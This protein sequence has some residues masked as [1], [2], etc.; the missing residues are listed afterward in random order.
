MYVGSLEKL[1]ESQNLIQDQW[2]IHPWMH[3]VYRQSHH[4]TTKLVAYQSQWSF[5]PVSSPGWT[6]VLTEFVISHPNTAVAQRQVLKLLAVWVVWSVFSSNLLTTWID[7]PVSLRQW[8]SNR[9]ESVCQLTTCSILMVCPE[10][11][12]A[13]V[14][15]LS[16]FIWVELTSRKTTHSYLPCVCWSS[17]VDVRVWIPLTS[18]QALGLHK[19]HVF[20]PLE[21]IAAGNKYI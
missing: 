16:L 9:Q 20:V 12:I 19:K 17:C 13:F 2:I 8:C 6:M 21:V 15:C 7:L 3:A 14:H 4:F 5:F 10:F 1:I 18:K 11:L